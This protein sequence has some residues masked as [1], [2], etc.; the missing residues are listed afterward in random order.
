LLPGHH[1]TRFGYWQ[2]RHHVDG[3]QLL[4]GRGVGVCVLPV[5]IA[6]APEVLLIE[7]R[8]TR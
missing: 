1:H 6:A 2:G 4:V 3:A 7:I 8:T 5:R